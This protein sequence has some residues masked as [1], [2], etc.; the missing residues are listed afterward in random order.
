MTFTFILTFYINNFSFPKIKSQTGVKI[1]KMLK[2]VKIAFSWQMR[3][4]ITG[5]ITSFAS[6]FWRPSECP[7]KLQYISLESALSAVSK[8]FSIF[9]NGA[10]LFCKNV[11]LPILV[12]TQQLGQKGGR[13]MKIWWFF[14]LLRDQFS[15]KFSEISRVDV[16]I[17]FNM[18]VV[19]IFPL[20]AP[21]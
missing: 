5:N 2:M 16:L 15:S 11:I 1:K 8:Y 10:H 12:N 6:N 19:T 14:A 7:N 3:I 9:Q 4:A 13:N 18:M 21:R 17:I 20:E